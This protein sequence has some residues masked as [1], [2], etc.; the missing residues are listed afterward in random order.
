MLRGDLYRIGFP[1]S[2]A[3]RIGRFFKRLVFMDFASVLL[4]YIKQTYLPE[5]FRK[6]GSEDFTEKD[7]HFFAMG[8]AELSDAFTSGR[9]E[10]PKNY[11]NRKEARSAYLLYF[12][13]TNF[14]K[15]LKCLHECARVSAFNSSD[16]DILDVGCGP[17]TAALACSS[18]FANRPLSITGVDQNREILKD[19]SAL[20]SMIGG[21][22]HSFLTI[23]E[24]IRPASI[25]QRLKGKRFDI[26]IAANVLN[27]VGGVKE[28]LRLCQTMLDDYLKDNG[29]VIVVDPALQKTTRALMEVRDLLN[30][31][32]LA[33][34]LHQDPCPMRAQNRRDW[35]HFYLEWKCPEII[36]KVD[37]LLEIR[38]DYLKMAYLILKKSTPP[39]SP[40]QKG[41]KIDLW[42]V[43][44][45]PLRSKGKC[46]F[47]L[48]GDG[49]LKRI[50]RLDR[51]RSDKN[52]VFD[53]VKRGDLIQIS[54]NA[55]RI[56]R[57][58]SLTIA[59]PFNSP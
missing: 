21:P 30:A 6:S 4:K 5:R 3:Y 22:H 9:R 37:R 8:A 18:F 39:S 17:G 59:F 57:N 29:V 55:D 46:E 53:Y 56:S 15:I 26:I 58:D 41:S 19:A 31:Q 40:L 25:G 2:S 12:T 38:H 33:P 34:C 14:A 45:S 23:N 20:F 36:R 7:V 32:I 49:R 51:D 11:F 44:S 24:E 52:R 48:C 35:C 47:V 16:L 28:Q 10:L 27:E 50:C 42:R 43:V 1:S 13:L 54:G